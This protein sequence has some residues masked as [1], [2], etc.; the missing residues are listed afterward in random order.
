MKKTLLIIILILGNFSFVLFSQSLIP[1]N[2][3]EIYAG[4]EDE[5]HE[6][7]IDNNGNIYLA[8]IFKSDTI[9]IGND[10]LKNKGSNDLFLI[11]FNSGLQLVFAQ[12]YINTGNSQISGLQVDTDNNIIITGS[13]TESLV[14][15]DT[16]IEDHS[17]G[18]DPTS[19]YLTKISAEGDVIWVKNY[20]GGSW[21][22]SLLT[23]A[24]N[25]LYLSCYFEHS[26]EFNTLSTTLNPT[27][28]DVQ[29][30]VKLNASG[31]EK[32]VKQFG[33]NL[34]LDNA[35]YLYMVGSYSDSITFDDFKLVTLSEYEN[36]NVYVAK[37]DTNGRV[38]WAKKFCEGEHALLMDVIYDKNSNSFLLSGTFKTDKLTF[39]D[40]IIQ[41]KGMA[42][43]FLTRIDTAANVLM[44]KSYGGARSDYGWGL[45]QINNNYTA[46]VATS[47]SESIVLGDYTIQ[48]EASNYSFGT[49]FILVVDND[50]NP[51][52][53][54]S[55]PK[56]ENQAIKSLL[57]DA[58]QNTY[59]I[60]DFKGNS[61]K[62]SSP[63]SDNPTYIDNPAIYLIG[64]NQG[65]VS[66]ESTHR[67]S[68]LISIYPNPASTSIR[69]HCND[70][71]KNMQ[72]NIFNADGK[73]IMQ[74]QLSTA[75]NEIN[76]EALP[77]GLYYIQAITNS[78]IFVTSL[79][80]R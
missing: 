54:K 52:W 16:V 42:E 62:K 5:V 23:D 53:A 35:G 40:V 43:I 41:N 11:K 70:E 79:V 44:S 69:I 27:S 39:D 59:M 31:Q 74:K 3:L 68:D 37:S 47:H 1:G 48:S 80:K 21:A 12:S 17:Q 20:A 76:I 71:I 72:V 55:F 51:V 19:T 78:E 60:G 67:S 29:F 46:L 38:L 8:G 6:T 24:N 4:I 56:A 49:F 64:F 57:T 65:T 30:L 32:W 2:V 22:K 66:V 13:F 7:A 25:N 28:R 61:V 18:Y 75:N 45:S 26:I 73:V 34:L 58:N 63:G 15:G 14:F 10:T 50:G 9:I 33:G 36:H 77:G